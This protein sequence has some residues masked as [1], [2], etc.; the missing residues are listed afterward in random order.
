MFIPT[1]GQRIELVRMGKDPDPIKPGTRG[2]VRSVQEFGRRER[3]PGYSPPA[4]VVGVEWDNG[5]TLNV[6][7]PEDKIKPA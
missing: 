5:R 4:Y 6:C 3:L 1:E 7:L 2:T